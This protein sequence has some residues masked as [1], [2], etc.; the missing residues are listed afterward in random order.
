LKDYPL[1]PEHYK[2]NLEE[3]SSYQ[4]ELISMKIGKNPTDTELISTLKRKEN[5]IID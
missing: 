3:L 2:P 5:Y 4:K 1:L